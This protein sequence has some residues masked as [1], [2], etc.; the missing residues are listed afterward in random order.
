MALILECQSSF[1]QWR[2]R[3]TWAFF[4]FLGL[5]GLAVPVLAWRRRWA[6]LAV[7]GGMTATSLA[8]RRNLAPAV[9]LAGPIL[10][11]AAHLAWRRLARQGPRNPPEPAAGRPAAVRCRGGALRRPSR[12]GCW[13]S[14]RR[15]RSGGW[16]WW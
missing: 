1:V 11:V 12:R 2:T 16:R 14:W 7:L 6:L 5:A 8:M 9:M 3:T 15:R 4:A 13:R 10:A